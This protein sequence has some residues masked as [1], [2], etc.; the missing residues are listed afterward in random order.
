[1]LISVTAKCLVAVHIAYNQCYMQVITQG[2]LTTYESS[3]QGKVVVLLHGWGD[4]A[5][6]LDDLRHVLSKRFKVL[7]PDLPGFGGTQAPSAIWGLDEY[8][9]FVSAFLKKL[10]IKQVYAFVAHSNGGAIA[11]RGLANGSLES[12]KLVLLASA[13]IRGTYSGRVKAIRYV[14][15]VGKLLTAPLPGKAKKRL[16]TRVYQT[17]GSDMLVAE[18]LQETFKRV[19]TDDV[20]ADAAHIAQPTMLIYG[21]NDTATPVRNGQ[22]LHEALADSTLEVIGEAGHF[23]FLDRP[24]EVQKAI[25]GFL[26]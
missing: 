13:G 3:G 24:H 1:M 20:R 6:G 16:R 12:E 18:H 15:K 5:S 26:L 21:E 17:V 4:R 8:A 2:L 11:I 22:L 23:V 19:V 10:E 9:N 7:A 14:T 25:E